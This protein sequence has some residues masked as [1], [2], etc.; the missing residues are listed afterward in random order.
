MVTK[1]HKKEEQQLTDSNTLQSEEGI[2][3][4]SKTAGYEFW[5]MLHKKIKNVS[6]VTVLTNCWGCAELNMV[7]LLDLAV[8]MVLKV[9]TD[10]IWCG[11]PWG[12]VRHP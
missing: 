1:M 4:R 9:A 7:S 3:G 8:Q 2:Y 6:I 11:M 12:S 10:N 5:K